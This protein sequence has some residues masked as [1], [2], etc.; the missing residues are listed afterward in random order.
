MQKLSDRLAERKR[1]RDQK[2][3]ESE[4][5]DTATQNLFGQIKNWLEDLTSNDLLKVSPIGGNGLTISEPEPEGITLVAEQRQNHVVALRREPAAAG[6]LHFVLQW[7]G[8]EWHIASSTSK[9]AEK[10]SDSTFENA[11]L[12]LLQ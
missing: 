8:G 5:W 2:K 12:K 11:M 6:G 4:K 1:E 9:R 3:L 10:L 7:S